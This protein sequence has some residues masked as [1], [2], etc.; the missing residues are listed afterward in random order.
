M[1]P[2]CGPGPAV[3]LHLVPE[4]AFDDF[5][6]PGADRAKVRLV[7]RSGH[8][9]RRG[10]GSGEDEAVLVKIRVELQERESGGHDPGRGISRS[11]LKLRRHGI[12][13]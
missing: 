12:P 5:P 10:V 6:I 8:R 11:G 4:E 7:M 3:S 13:G 9:V 2:Q 1:R